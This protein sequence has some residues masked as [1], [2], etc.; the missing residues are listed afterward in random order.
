MAI[1]KKVVVAKIDPLS[2]TGRR[3]SQSSLEHSGVEPDFVAPV[4]GVSGVAGALVIA[5]VLSPSRGADIRI[6][7]GRH[8]LHHPAERD[9]VEYGPV[10]RVAGSLDG[11]SNRVFFLQRFENEIRRT[12]NYTQ[13][14]ALLMFDID[15]FKGINDTFGHSAG[16]IV[17]KK[18]ADIIRKNTR[19]SDLVGATAAMNSWCS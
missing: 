1:Q 17:L 6:H 9:A 8:H 11:V 2:S 15:K 12:E 16:D 10:Q 4:F 19:S 18:L 7:A 3:S 14:L 5:D 13:P